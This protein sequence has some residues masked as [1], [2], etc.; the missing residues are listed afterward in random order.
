MSEQSAETLVGKK[1]T[2]W[3]R[4]VKITR[5][6]A[7]IIVRYATTGR[8]MPSLVLP[9]TACVEGLAGVGGTVSE[10]NGYLEVELE[11]NQTHLYRWPQ[12]R[13]ELTD[14]SVIESTSLRSVS[15]G[16]SLRKDSD[17]DRYF[18]RETTKLKLDRWCW[19]SAKTPVA[20]VGLLR[21]V[22]LKHHNANLGVECD[23]HSS[24]T[25]I[26][27]QGN[28]MMPTLKKGAA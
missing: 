19:R 27:L 14:S 4:A 13:V 18:S 23:G 26:R 12:I 3:G 8:R 22:S 24:F 15:H 7:D 21:G 6:L 2:P 16:M 11:G 20:W 25:S 5:P 1:P 10:A 17:S 9:S 28:A